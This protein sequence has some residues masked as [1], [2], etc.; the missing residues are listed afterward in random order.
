MHHLLYVLSFSLLLLRDFIISLL[1]I[2]Q[3]KQWLLL[4]LSILGRHHH[5]NFLSGFHTKTHDKEWNL[6]STQCSIWY[7]SSSKITAWRKGFVWFLR[8]CTVTYFRSLYLVDIFVPCTEPKL[9]LSQ[10]YLGPPGYHTS[11]TYH[12]YSFFLDIYIFQSFVSYYHHSLLYVFWSFEQIIHWICLNIVKHGKI[13]HLWCF[14]VFLESRHLFRSLSI[15]FRSNTFTFWLAIC[16]LANVWSVPACLGL[17]TCRETQWHLSWPTKY[18]EGWASSVHSPR[19][20]GHFRCKSKWGSEGV[21]THSSKW[22]HVQRV[23]T[24]L[25][26]SHVAHFTLSWALYWGRRYLIFQNICMW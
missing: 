20:S 21:C 2:A 4:S 12:N 5:H 17:L 6:Q 13:K 9:S 1:G 22:H 10:I 3:I 14:E 11:T 26:R 7:F 25:K 18:R 8:L 16:L 23:E 24:R 15:P 19:W